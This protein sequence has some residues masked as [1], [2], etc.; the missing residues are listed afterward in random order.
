M[1]L[2]LWNHSIIY[3]N[4]LNFIFQENVICKCSRDSS[5]QQPR[6]PIPITVAFSLGVMVG[7]CIET[8]H[9]FLINSWG[10]KVDG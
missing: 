1:V 7:V 8:T 3:L 4:F 2:I 10:G 9:T 5:H 6:L